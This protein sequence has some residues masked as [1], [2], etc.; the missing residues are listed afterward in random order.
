MEHHNPYPVPEDQLKTVLISNIHARESRPRRNLYDMAGLFSEAEDRTDEGIGTLHSCS[1]GARRIPLC[2]SAL[3]P[4]DSSSSRV[5]RSLPNRPNH[6]RIVSP[7]HPRCAVR[8][9]CN[10][11]VG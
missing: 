2:C 6:Q 4:I 3:Q 7:A 11:L 8:V 9:S 1:T 5:G 10:I